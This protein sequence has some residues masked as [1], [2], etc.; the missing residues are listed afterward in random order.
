MRRRAPTSF[1]LAVAVVLGG[2]A[3]CFDGLWLEGR[4]CQSDT[5]CGP[6]LF[7]SKG[8]CGGP[9]C[10]IDA[11]PNGVC[12]CPGPSNWACAE[13][14]PATQRKIDV[15]LV[16]DDAGSSLWNDQTRMS[17]IGDAVLDSL[18]QTLADF[19]IGIT[20]SDLGNPAC[21]ETTPPV[22]RLLFSSCRNR[23]WD[24]VDGDEDVR[25][26]C[27]AACAHDMIVADPTPLDD[28]DEEGAAP[29]PW[30]EGNAGVANT[31]QIPPR[32]ALGCLIPQGIAGC[33]FG[34][35]LEALHTALDRMED[36][37]DPGF[38]FLR[39]DA[40]LL[41]LVVT[42][43][44]DCSA[45][46]VSIFDPQGAKTF[47]GD[48]GAM[49]ATQAVCW[50]AGVACSG[51]PGTYDDCAPTDLAADGSPADAAAGVLHSLSRYEA[52]LA[53]VRA[54]KLAVDPDL[55]VVV[56]GIA[57]VPEGYPNTPLVYAD[58]DAP[59]LDAYGIG[60]GC[61][62]VD[63]AFAIPPVRVRALAQA[64]APAKQ[65]K[66]ESNLASAC[67]ADPA[68][69]LDPV[70]A[71]LPVGLEPLCVEACVQDHVTSVPG[72]QPECEVA[73]IDDD[74]LV[75]IPHCGVSGGAPATVEDA[76]ICYYELYGD[77]VTDECTGTGSNLQLGF[78]NGPGARP[79]GPIYASCEPSGDPARDCPDFAIDGG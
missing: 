39:E 5:D 21:G 16:L 54:D 47:W 61:G 15:L 78:L 29:R 58:A 74:T 33:E 14:A 6:Q 13:L 20:T 65:A 50:N 73:W 60:P 62:S 19:R 17:A 52:R 36:P 23:V 7:C 25:Q 30:L 18:D 22:G 26:D 66:G 45:Q 76:P 1:G 46:D 41:V 44:V 57:G 77:Q 69:G 3:G 24:F 71:I 27:F 8:F 55:Q 42:D 51:G 48:P 34:Q 35:P 28:E 49:Q 72:V 56:A 79:P 9:Q 67:A 37:E 53:Q 4:P 11:L 70:R 2:G 59:F 43:G 40:H 38:G 64:F 68:P 12:P 75:E 32:E 31:G 10:P 63:D